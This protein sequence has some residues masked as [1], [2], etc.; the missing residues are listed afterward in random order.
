MLKIKR[1]LAGG[2][3]LL[4]L[5]GAVSCQHSELEVGSEVFSVGNIASGEE[6]MSAVSAVIEQL[7]EESSVTEEASSTAT[8]VPVVS[9]ASSL[10]AT[11]DVLSSVTTNPDLG[12]S[13]ASQAVVSESTADS[14]AE[15]SASVPEQNDAPVFGGRLLSLLPEAKHG[16][17]WVMSGG[18]GLGGTW[19]KYETIFQLDWEDDIFYSAATGDNSYYAVY[20]TQEQ[21]LVYYFFTEEL[22]ITAGAV[23]ADGQWQPFNYLVRKGGEADGE[24]GRWLNGIWTPWEG[25]VTDEILQG[26][27]SNTLAVLLD[28]AIYEGEWEVRRAPLDRLTHGIYVTGAH[29]YADFSG[30]ST[31]NTLDDVYAIDSAIQ[32]KWVSEDNPFTLHMLTDGML[33][34]R[35]VYDQEQNEFFV[36]KLYYYPDYVVDGSVVFY[37]EERGGP[38]YDFSILPEDRFWE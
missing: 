11:T 15:A 26:D 3:V 10:S 23:G 22:S 27:P 24:L 13:A 16:S 21:G 37:G 19:D 9:S 2:L 28:D 14:S 6:P 17:A 30:L 7:I 8:Q 29:S 35:Y 1:I 33:V 20:R 5:F 32:R 36:S 34:V 18:I 38:L 12:S 4:L 25:E 31:E